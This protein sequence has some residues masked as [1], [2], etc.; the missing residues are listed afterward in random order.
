MVPSKKGYIL[1][2]ENLYPKNIFSLLQN[3]Y[4]ALRPREVLASDLQIV[5]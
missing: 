4:F 1:N 2:L 3:L 5:N